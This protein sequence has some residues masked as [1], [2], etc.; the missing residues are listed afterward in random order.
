MCIRDSI[1]GKLD[2]ENIIDL[3]PYWKNLVDYDSITVDLTPYGRPDPTLYVKDIREEQND[4]IVSSS[5]FLRNVKAYYTVTAARLGEMV[6]EYEGESL[7]DYPGDLT[8]FTWQ[9]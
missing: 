6:V 2:G 4:I 1:R 5:A 7:D 8:H 3:P 9:G